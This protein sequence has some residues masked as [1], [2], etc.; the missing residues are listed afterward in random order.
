MLRLAAGILLTALL[1][2]GAP[3]IELAETDGR[4]VWIS[5]GCVA[6]GMSPAEVF[7]VYVDSVADAPP[8]AGAYRQQDGG[9]VFEPRY[10]PS[11]GARYRAECKPPAGPAVVRTFDIPE[12]DRTP[13]TIVE[14]VYP[15]GEELP[16]NLLKFYVHFTAPMSRGEAYR[17]V[18]LLDG[19]GTEIELPFLEID[20]ELWD[21]NYQ[22]LTLLFDPGRIKSGLV[23]N[24]EVGIALHAG[25]SYTLVIDAGWM[26]AEGKQLKQSY[27]K[28]FSV[29]KGDTDPPNPGTWKVAWPGGGTEP[30]TIDFPEALD[31]ALLSRVVTVTTVA[32][33][34]VLGRVEISRGETR[35][36]F[37]PTAPWAP[38]R[39]QIEAL[40]ILE[41]LAGN[42]INRPFEVDVFE[43]V[44]ERVTRKSVSIP[45]S[46]GR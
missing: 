32:G 26:D 3:S 8:I 46:V 21:A 5:S 44:E 25:R 28:R 2:A 14:Q 24:R 15:S 6:A 16:E 20:E 18:R 30:V 29:V 43:K 22:R 23:P 7:S 17:H 35:W 39:Y 45:F 9:I 10:P 19:A 37:I 38:G 42:S 33:K 36:E 1:F 34:P 11:P 13:T 40:T 41:D 4:T 27:T 12:S 31:Q